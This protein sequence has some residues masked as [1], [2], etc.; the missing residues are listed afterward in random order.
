MIFVHPPDNVEEM[1][2]LLGGIAFEAENTSL[3]S[4]SNYAFDA[5]LCDGGSEAENYSV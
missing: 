4:A 3:L 5:L 1:K 2:A